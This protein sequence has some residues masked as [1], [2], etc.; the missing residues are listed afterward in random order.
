MQT[1]I[2]RYVLAI[3]IFLPSICL[4][5]V[6]RIG[7][8]PRNYYMRTALEIFFIAMELYLAVPLAIAM[9]P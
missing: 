8:L 7:M 4:L 2:S 6:D 1:A 5:G 3:P 9:Y